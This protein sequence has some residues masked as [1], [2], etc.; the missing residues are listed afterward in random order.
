MKFNTTYLDTLHEKEIPQ[1]QQLRIKK[2]SE[3]TMKPFEH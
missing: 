1:K 2:C 3:C